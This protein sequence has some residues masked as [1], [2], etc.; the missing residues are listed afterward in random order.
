MLKGNG[1]RDFVLYLNVRFLQ[2]NNCVSKKRNREIK[3]SPSILCRE[4]N[5]LTINANNCCTWEIKFPSNFLGTREGWAVL[6][7]VTN[8]DCQLHD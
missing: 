5:R 2:N 7:L 4:W 3:E 8:V 6:V 1:D